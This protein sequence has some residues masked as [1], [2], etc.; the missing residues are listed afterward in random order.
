VTP[1]YTIDATDPTRPPVLVRRYD[2]DRPHYAPIAVA[3]Q[4]H[5]DRAPSIR[6]VTDIPAWHPP[7]DV[8]ADYCAAVLAWRA[9]DTTTE[10]T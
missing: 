5:A 7:A 6:I 10:A 9:T 4:W 8:L 2:R 3:H 1:P